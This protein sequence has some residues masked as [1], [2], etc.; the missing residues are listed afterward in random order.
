[1]SDDALVQADQGAVVASKAVENMIHIDNSI[2]VIVE[3]VNDLEKLSTDILKISEVL[4]G[5]ASKT[6]L[7]ALNAAIEAARAGEHGRGFAVVA[8]EVK[9]LAES[10]S[11]SAKSVGDLVKVITNGIKDI[12]EKAKF[13]LEWSEKGKI[14]VNN[15]SDKFIQITNT[16]HSLKDDN[17]SILIQSTKLSDVSESM[18]SVVAT[19]VSNRVVIS[20]GLEAVD[21]IKCDD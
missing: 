9:K 20:D 17:S 21:E 16:V 10:S 2:S 11:D 4:Q 14:D 5:V 8:E 6:N 19:I 18:S 12:G 15:T 1:M 13:S 3:T 7:L